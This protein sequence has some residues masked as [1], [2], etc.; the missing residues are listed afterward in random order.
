M[1]VNIIGF[2]DL[3]V[4]IDKIWSEMEP[5]YTNIPVNFDQNNIKKI[6]KFSQKLLF[7]C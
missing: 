5:F 4:D 6:K 1:D 2:D 3:M 7:Y